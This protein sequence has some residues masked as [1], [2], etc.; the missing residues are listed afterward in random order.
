MENLDIGLK[1]TVRNWWLPL[2]SGTLFVL[3]GIWAFVAPITSLLALASLFM[4]SFFVTG[5]F[6]IMY[7]L[8]NKSVLENWGWILGGGILNVLFSTLLI[9]HP[10]LSAA[11]LPI[12]VGFILLFRSIMGISWA[13]DMQ[14]WNLSGWKW[15]MLTSFLGIIFSS[16][17]IL[18]PMFGGL[19]I[20]YYTA[21][22]LILWGLVQILLSVGMKKLNS[23]LM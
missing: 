6:E 1:D 3:L 4:L 18:N 20:V 5:L 8:S 17:M 16:I 21:A 14:R 10:G 19:A 22:T 11:V 7:A 13:L 23:D 15:A 9:Y 12:F 2:I